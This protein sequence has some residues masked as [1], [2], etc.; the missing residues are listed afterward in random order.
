MTMVYAE[1]SVRWA[2][3]VVSR[4]HNNT[5]MQVYYYPGWTTATHYCIE[6]R[7]AASWQYSVPRTMQPGSFI[8]CQ[9]DLL[10]WQLHWLPVQHRINCMLDVM[11]YKSCSSTAPVHLSHHIKWCE[12]A[13]TLH[14]C[15]VVP[16]I[17]CL[18]LARPPTSV[19][20]CRS[21]NLG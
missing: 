2:P 1:W 15:R 17:V 8:K 12:S 10:L 9:G 5:G 6:L 18:E 3:S 13:R 4:T 16:C 21:S 7:L 20:H 19:V 14:S 11:T